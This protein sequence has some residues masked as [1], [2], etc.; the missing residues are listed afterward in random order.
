MSGQEETAADAS[1]IRA[2]AA[3]LSTRPRDVLSAL[4]PAAMQALYDVMQES[5]QDPW[6]ARAPGPAT[7]A[8]VRAAAAQAT[9]TQHDAALGDRSRTAKGYVQANNNQSEASRS[10]AGAGSAGEHDTPAHGLARLAGVSDNGVA[11]SVSTRAVGSTFETI[12]ENA[13]LNGGTLATAEEEPVVVVFG[14]IAMDLV[15][16][17]RGG[18]RVNDNIPATAFT[19]SPGGKGA[20]EAV[21]IALLGA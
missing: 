3:L 4:S 19:I 9:T 14:S 8:D 2:A 21:A 15:A 11:G 20:N 18:P 6:M 13:T 16:K 10:Q 12:M 5:R 1:G 7:P 17:A